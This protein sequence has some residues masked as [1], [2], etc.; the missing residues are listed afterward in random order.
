MRTMSDGVD[1]PSS[2]TTNAGKDGLLEIPCSTARTAPGA[3]VAMPAFAARFDDPVTC[4]PPTRTVSPAE[5]RKPA[6]AANPAKEPPPVKVEVPVPVETIFPPVSRKSPAV[7]KMPF[8]EVIPFTV[9]E[10][11]TA[12]ILVARIEPPVTVIPDTVERP[13]AVEME[14]PPV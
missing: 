4:S 3:E 8:E 7:E 13:P 2:D 14:M 10:P 9:V 11:K 5:T 1:V 6:D 12:P